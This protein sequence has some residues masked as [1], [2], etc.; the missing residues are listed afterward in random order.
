MPRAASRKGVDPARGLA[1]PD[2]LVGEL[3]G[4]DAAG[5]QLG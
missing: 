1:I 4:L 2:A 3:A 5:Q